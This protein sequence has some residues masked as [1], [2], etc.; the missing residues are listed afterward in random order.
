MLSLKIPV[1]Y[2]KNM[3]RNKSPN[4]VTNKELLN[5]TQGTVLNYVMNPLV[6]AVDT[7]WI[8]KLNN[9]A[10]LAGQGTSDRIFNSMFLVSSFAPAVIIPIISKYHAIGDNDKVIS[11]IS[12]SVFLVGLIGLFLSTGVFIFKDSI[13]SAIIPSSA[14]SYKYAIQYLEIRILSLG[15][16]LLN[17]LAFASMRGQK[18][19]NTPIKINLCSQI[20]NMVLDPILMLKMGVKGIALG[21]VISE[22]VSFTLFYSSMVRK[23]LINFSLIDTKLIKTLIKRGFSVQVRSICLSLIYLFG[24][25]Q[26]QQIDLSGNIAA[27]HV[28]QLQ[29]FE[30][31]YIFTY[32]FGLVCPI[33][34]PRYPNKKQVKYA[35]YRFGTSISVCM[36]FINFMISN[37]F[38]KIFSKNSDVIKISGTVTPVSSIFQ[39]ICGL[40][41]VT[42]GM[43]QG[44][45]MYNCL[46]IGTFLST[47]LYLLFIRLC[48]TLPQMW[49]VMAL[50][51]GFRGILNS[52]LMELEEKKENKDN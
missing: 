30:I 12:T 25:R 43:I 33:I 2:I 6:G 26:A 37:K 19:I 39:L 5:L 31:G 29:L 50:S 3:V 32:S 35:L 15:F 23:N 36:M 47:T 46:G 27:A 13:T 28:L 17:S 49:L 18:D 51:T 1:S 22:L 48:N 14:K 4:V 16:A 45:G 7:F 41:S 8:S 40:T 20:V 42:E 44:Y 21:T 52:K 24:F 10:I 34:I 38:M 9:D 11:I